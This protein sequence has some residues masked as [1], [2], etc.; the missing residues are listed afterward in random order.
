MVWS[1]SAHAHNFRP[2]HTPIQKK[3]EWNITVTSLTADTWLAT[4]RIVHK[5]VVKSSMDVVM[6]GTSDSF[7][8]LH[9]CNSLDSKLFLHKTMPETQ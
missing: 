2:K 9:N 6:H 1:K 3:G 5:T 4:V 8:S 7:A